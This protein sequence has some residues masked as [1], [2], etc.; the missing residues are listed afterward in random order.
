M[1]VV[2][3]AV[4]AFFALGYLILGGADIGTGM[5]LP[6]L[7]RTDQERRLV[8]TG[9]APFFLANEV[10][11]V[12][13]IGLLAGAFPELEAVVVHDLY[14]PFTLL[15][16]GWVVRDMGLWLRGRVDRRA[17][18]AVADVAVF[19]ASWCMALG[20][21]ALIGA[22]LGGPSLIGMAAAAVL[23]GLHGLA[24]SALRLTGVLR[25]RAELGLPGAAA[26]FL[27]TSAAVAV[28]GILAGAR[29]E[30]AGMAADRAS[31]AFLLPP[32]LA[33]LPVLMAAQAWMWWMFRHRVTR[34][35]YL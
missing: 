8:L 27:L 17:W 29:L 1:E 20:W 18:R 13:T 33:V 21:G 32:T 26:R 3:V 22:V 28:I 9:I 12:A 4:L 35:S 14:V 11:L 7:G 10:W 30:P 15:L 19:T 5:M 31:L 2:A 24:F 34:P 6:Y 23:F 16:F 25:R